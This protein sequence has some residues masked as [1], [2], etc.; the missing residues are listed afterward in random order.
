MPDKLNSISTIDGRYNK[1]VS[2]LSNY[3]SESAL[4]R[5]RLM[6]EVEYLISLGEEKKLAELPLISK[7][8]QNSL[9]KIYERFDSISARRIKKIET[10]TNHDVKAI[11]FYISEKLRKM[12]KSNLIPWVHFGLTSED[13]NNISYSLMWKEG[14][15]NV[16][17]AKCYHLCTHLTLIIIMH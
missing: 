8:V 2:V 3:F 9:R 12:N 17:L 5:Y 10:Q 14:I 1:E 15:K 6:V 16:Y 13:V 11:E 4:M 7:T